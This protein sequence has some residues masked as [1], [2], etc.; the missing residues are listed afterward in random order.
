MK[1][2]AS[3]T[4]SFCPLEARDAPLNWGTHSVEDSCA[5]SDVRNKSELLRP[6][7]HEVL[8]GSE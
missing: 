5:L 3:R 2:I 1:V 8:N 7:D 4:C 6:Q